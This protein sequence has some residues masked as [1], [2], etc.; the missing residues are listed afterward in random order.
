MAWT[1]AELRTYEEGLAGYYRRRAVH[2]DAQFQIGAHPIRESWAELA[3]AMREALAGRAVLELACGTGHF[4]GFAAEAAAHVTATDLADEMLQVA[5]GKIFPRGNVAFR[6]ADAFV[7]EALPGSFDAALAVQWFSH[8]PRARY[9]AFL[10][11][12]NRRLG[13]GARVFL[14]DGGHDA[15]RTPADS[16]GR[17]PYL[18]PGCEDVYTL[19]TVPGAA[20]PY[21]IIKNHFRTEEE[22]RAVFAPYGRDL[23]AR[24]GRHFWH[25]SYLTV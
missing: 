3:A 15:A 23:E 2:Y 16:P 10:G 4:T 8:L 24:I 6:T 17:A 25:V 18:K 22:L 14:A 12:L 9:A 5:R 7:L 13:S 1:D 11:G 19:R 20:R 21:E